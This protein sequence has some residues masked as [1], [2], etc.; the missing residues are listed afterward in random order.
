[1]TKL[2]SGR[3]DSL[4]VFGLPLIVLLYAASFFLPVLTFMGTSISGWYA[5]VAV[6][7]PPCC[8]ASLHGLALV[9]AWFWWLANPSFVIALVWLAA[10]QN[11]IGAVLGTLA[12]ISAWSFGFDPAMFRDYLRGIL[13]FD[14]NFSGFYCWS[15]S[16]ALL[17]VIGIWRVLRPQTGQAAPR[18]THETASNPARLLTSPIT[19]AV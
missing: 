19:K 7:T 1:M 11:R 3:H 2:A 16:M 4:L 12:L 8:D 10:G 18:G 17:T 6:M 13:T 15:G 9:G 5:F 14:F